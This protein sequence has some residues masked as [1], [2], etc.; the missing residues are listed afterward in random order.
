MRREEPPQ[1]DDETTMDGWGREGEDDRNT[2]Q[3]AEME[4]G[5]EAEEEE[6]GKRRRRDVGEGAYKWASATDTEKSQ[7]GG[8]AGRQQVGRHGGEG[9]DWHGRH[10]SPL[11]SPAPDAMPAKELRLL[12]ASTV[13]RE[14]NSRERIM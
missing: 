3:P 2:L 1:P 7:G 10:S 13:G 8:E 5:D 12:T 11:P 9:G 6:R 14:E 4:W